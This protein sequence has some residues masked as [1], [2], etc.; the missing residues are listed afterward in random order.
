MFRGR[1]TG[2]VWRAYNWLMFAL[3]VAAI[4]L[5]QNG[6]PSEPALLGLIVAA[7]LSCVL[8]ID[9]V[10]TWLPR[11]L[12][13]RS[14]QAARLAS[15]WADSLDIPATLTDSTGKI[16]YQNAADRAA[17]K[18]SLGEKWHARL[19]DHR[20]ASQILAAA[21]DQESWFGS[22]DTTLTNGFQL[23]V[24]A[25]PF[26]GGPGRVN[27]ILFLQE[28]VAI[29]LPAPSG[30]VEEPTRP[31]SMANLSHEIRTPLTSILGFTDVLIDELART[32]GSE[33]SVSATK[34]IKRNGEYLLTLVN[35]ILDLSKWKSGA[36][37]VDRRPCRIEELA[38]EASDLFCSRFA[39]KN[40][41]F[42][43]SMGR[44]LP[45]TINTDPNRLR[46]ILINLL[47]NALKFTD[48][49]NVRLSF[50][51]LASPSRK[52]AI[53][54]EDSGIGISEETLQNLF[55]P[56]RQAD[57]VR[58]KFGGT[59]LGLSI[60]RMLTRAL[61]GEIQVESQLGIGSKFIATIDIGGMEGVPL[62]VT[63]A[64]TRL[65]RDTFLKE[66]IRH[67]PQGLR[68]LAVEDNI[69]N[70]H[71]LGFLLD[72][73]KANLTIVGD[74][75]DGVM[76]FHRSMKR[77]EPYDLILMD[78]EMPIMNGYEATRLIRETV[79]IIALTAH[80]MDVDMDRCLSAGCNDWIAKPIDRLTFYRKLAN[81]TYRSRSLSVAEPLASSATAVS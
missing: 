26:N 79:P 27:L 37:K 53:T 47:S 57:G 70:Q 2:L 16:L 55:Q 31:L 77:E 74:G 33:Q 20:L 25:L 63:P 12:D 14:K 43:I 8:M 7:S 17:F 6:L 13:R 80:A 64:H 69:D 39:E 36:I 5:Q 51:L 59:G 44:F 67:V 72:K 76:E 56:F 32:N 22:A 9:R 58:K 38:R 19:A 29:K 54:V 62:I 41:T 42:E 75:Q 48:S 28:F 23:R 81:N 46:Q 35:D 78:I 68:I 15:Q 4:G 71:L 24:Q 21:R 3:A 61:G 30:I 65:E 60:T 40:V 45:A 50:E 18:H 73:V 10:P 1:G 49:G 52:L 34:T 11:D 66:S